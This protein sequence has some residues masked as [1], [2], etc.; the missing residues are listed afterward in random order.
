M[1]SSRLR[2]GAVRALRRRAACSAREPSRRRRRVPCRTRRPSPPS[3]RAPRSGRGRRSRLPPRCPRRWGETAPPCRCPGMSGSSA[4]SRL[5]WSVCAMWARSENSRALS[6]RGAQRRPSSSASSRSCSS[7]RRP[8]RLVASVIAPNA[9]PRAAI[10][11]TIAERIPVA[12]PRR[13]S[14]VR[15]VG[16]RLRAPPGARGAVPREPSASRSERPEARFSPGAQRGRDPAPRAGA[17]GPRALLPLGR[18]PAPS[19]EVDEAASRR[20]GDREVRHLRAAPFRVERG[21]S[22]RPALGQEPL[23]QLGSL[24]LGDVLDHVDRHRHRAVAVADRRCLDRRPA[25]VTRP[26]VR[27]SAPRP[28]PA[29]S[30]SARRPGSSSSGN[31]LP[32]SS[33]ISK[34]AMISAG[35]ADSSAS[36]ESKPSSSTAASLAN[37]SLPSGAWAVTASATPLRMA[38]S[39]SRACRAS[40]RGDLFEAQQLLALLLGLLSPVMSRT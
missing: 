36:L 12:R 16:A 4:G 37:S 7:K 2:L 24:V 5:C 9:R 31:G 23:R 33:R 8:P 30:T 14:A 28:A 6:S 15:F 39:W 35:A 18:S 38:S 32:C 10:G 40:T 27:E 29:P 19:S 34:R 21:A 3:S 1:S 25:L 17:L 22:T 13:K 11:A 26:H 20:A